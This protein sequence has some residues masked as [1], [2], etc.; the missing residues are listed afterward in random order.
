MD[1]GRSVVAN[2]KDI[3]VQ[4]S[5]IYVML[6]ICRHKACNILFG[7]VTAGSTDHKMIIKILPICV[8]VIYV[9]LEI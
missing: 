8:Y 5:I 2:E 7:Y 1:Q 3:N 9:A 6:L 4:H